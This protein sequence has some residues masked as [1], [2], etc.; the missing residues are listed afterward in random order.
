MHHSL[1]AICYLQITTYYSWLL[2]TSY[3]LLTLTQ[4]VMR[5]DMRY[6]I[7]TL[8]SVEVLK[9]LTLSELT[10]TRL[11]PKPTPPRAHELK[12]LRGSSIGSARVALCVVFWRYLTRVF[13]VPHVALA[14]APRLMRF[15]SVAAAEGCA[16]R[17]AS[18]GGR[19]SREAGGLA[20]ALP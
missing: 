9:S 2:A 14:P 10:V 18:K 4:V 7:K 1:L 8:R 20:I 3:R 15:S 11:V 13:R 12:L 6:I 5:T 17:S 16:L 19:Q